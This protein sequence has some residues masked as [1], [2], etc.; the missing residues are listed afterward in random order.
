MNSK[1]YNQNK[2]FEGVGN[3]WRNTALFVTS[4]E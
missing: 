1:V 3:E 4:E 2:W